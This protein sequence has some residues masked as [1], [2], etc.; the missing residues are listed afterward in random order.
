MLLWNPQFIKARTPRHAPSPSVLYHAIQHVIDTFG[1]TV[2]AQGNS[3]FNAMTWQ[4]ANSILE[5]AKQGYLSDVAVVVL[6]E[7]AGVDKYGLQKWKCLRGTNSVEG[8]PHGDIYRKFGALHGMF[9]IIM[10][11]SLIKIY[12]SSWASF[13]C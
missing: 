6:Y 10:F 12:S 3:L 13:S 2:D 4:K 7:K 9:T 5:L 8:G 1:G 11:S